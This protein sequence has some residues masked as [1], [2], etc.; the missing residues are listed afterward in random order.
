[1][2]KKKILIVD[3]EPDILFTIEEI[4]DFCGYKA[5]TTSSGDEA[6]RIAQVKK[7]DLMIVDYH[8]PGWDGLSIVKKLGLSI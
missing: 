8:M 5:F 4:C 1:M 2:T 7:P 3:D 6:I